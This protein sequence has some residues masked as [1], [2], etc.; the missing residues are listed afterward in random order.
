LEEGEIMALADGRG[1]GTCLSRESLLS[2]MQEALSLC[3]AVWLSGPL[4]DLLK[5]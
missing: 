1:T 2:D 4:Y 3:C 5:R